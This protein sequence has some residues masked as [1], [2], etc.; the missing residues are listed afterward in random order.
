MLATWR[1][2]VCSPTTS[3]AGIV[4]AGFAEGLDTRDLLEARQLLTDL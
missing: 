3:F 4:Y 2:T 1:F